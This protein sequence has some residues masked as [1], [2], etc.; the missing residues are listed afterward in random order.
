MQDLIDS[1]VLYIIKQKISYTCVILKHR[2]LKYLYFLRSLEIEMD[3]RY[4]IHFANVKN[5]LT[6]SSVLHEWIFPLK[7]FKLLFLAVRFAFPPVYV[8]L[9]WWNLMF[10]HNRKSLSW[11]TLR[12]RKRAEKDSAP[13]KSDIKVEN[14]LRKPKEILSSKV[15]VK[16][17][18]MVCVCVCAAHPYLCGNKHW[19]HH[20]PH[21]RLSN[22]SMTIFFFLRI[23]YWK[24][25]WLLHSLLTI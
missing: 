22:E 1:R 5:R 16:V 24:V 14:G 18:R 21:L 4:S 9:M 6:V 13:L 25:E 17:S 10:W 11:N 2:V 23:L 7:H 19:T 12:A 15:T 20:S 3:D 8:G